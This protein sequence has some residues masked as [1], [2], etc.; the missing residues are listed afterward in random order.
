M[1][2]QSPRRRVPPHVVQLGGTLLFLVLVLLVVN[3]AGWFYYR[4]IRASWERELNRSLTAVAVTAASRVTSDELDDLLQKGEYGYAYATLRSQLERT[5]TIT[6]WIRNVFIFDRN[7]RTV[8]DLDADP[9]LAARPPALALDRAAPAE[10]LLGRAGAS[11]LYEVGGRHYKAAYAPV[12]PDSGEVRAVLAVDADAGFFVGLERLR[13][14]LLLVAGVSTLAILLLGVFFSRATRG[15]LRAEERARRSETLASMGQ[16]A[17][18]MAHEIRNPLAIIRATSERLKGAPPQ[19]EIWHYIP[20]EVERLNSILSTYLDFARSDP[21]RPEV[22]DLK[23]SLERVRML[24]EPDLGKRGIRVVTR[25]PD[26]AALLRGSPAGIRQV[27]LNLVLNAEDAMPE[28]GELTLALERR[29][30]SW[31]CEVRD[32][33]HGIP[34]EELRRVFDPFYSRKERGTGLGLAVV[35]RIVREHRGR[36]EVDSREGRGTVFRLIFPAAEAATA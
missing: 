28:G 26:G 15:L 33:G 21:D 11:A 4:T 27:L 2:I 9:P 5:R 6:G 14:D 7:Q 18:T 17:A 10:A 25:Y 31:V 29:D 19:D 3:A 32:T 35:E 22:L 36:I 24:C 23:E 1:R 12:R 8:L 34:R 16:L 20:E 30:R 13:R